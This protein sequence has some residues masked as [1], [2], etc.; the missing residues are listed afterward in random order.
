MIKQNEGTADRILRIVVGTA[1]LIASFVALDAAGGSAGGIVLA[2]IGA[3]LVLTGAVGYCM[4]YT[5]FHFST[6]K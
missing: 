1:F 3:M 5:V 6:K 4:L 2:V